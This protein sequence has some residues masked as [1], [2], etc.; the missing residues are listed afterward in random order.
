M[1][2]YSRNLVTSIQAHSAPITQ[3]SVIPSTSNISDDGSSSHLIATSSHDLT[4]QISRLSLKPQT[5]GSESE[6]RVLASLHLHTSPVSSIA[7]NSTGTHLLTSS[8]DGLVGFWDTSIPAQDE[9]PEVESEGD[10]KKRRKLG[11]DGSGEKVKRKA[12]LLVLKSHTSRVSRVIFGHVGQGNGE[13]TAYSC[14]FDSTVRMW[15]TENGICTHTIVS[16]LRCR[17][18]S[19]Y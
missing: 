3:V 8:W 11:A 6:S 12:P 19:L 10:R 1:F 4:A 5:A 7:S 14:G 15:D 9:V 16:V 17:S 13:R 18:S 2:D